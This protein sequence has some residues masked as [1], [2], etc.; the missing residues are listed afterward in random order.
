MAVT[1]RRLSLD[2]DVRILDLAST[3]GV[4]FPLWM[5]RRSA[6]ILVNNAEQLD[7]E[8]LQA[9]VDVLLRETRQRVQ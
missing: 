6:E 4:K 3:K 9:V 7:S 8:E 1:R 2:G 5:V